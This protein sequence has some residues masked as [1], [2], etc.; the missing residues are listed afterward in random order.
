MGL[1]GVVSK[2]N[3]TEDLFLGTDYLS[4]RFTEEAGIATFDPDL[5]FRRMNRSIRGSQFKTEFFPGYRN[6]RGRYGI[7][8][9]TK[10]ANFHS[11]E[12][13]IVK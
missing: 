1:F 12:E 7:D 2:E 3:I 6:L 5:G 10:L 9:G 4:H 11:D 8:I 13:N